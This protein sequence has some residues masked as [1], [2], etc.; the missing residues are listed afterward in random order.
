ME[1]S[2]SGNFYHAHFYDLKVGD[3]TPVDVLAD[4]TRIMGI[5]AMKKWDCVGLVVN[6]KEE[7]EV[8][9][10]ALAVYMS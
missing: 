3:E 9:I 6:E 2:P 4:G 5:V 1:K 10:T 7:I 8:I